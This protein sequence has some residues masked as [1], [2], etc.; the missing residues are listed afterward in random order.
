MGVR[1]RHGKG[2]QR[3]TA[4]SSF[5]FDTKIVLG[6]RYPVND[7]NWVVA[8]NGHYAIVLSLLYRQCASLT[9]VQLTN[10]QANGIK[11]MFVPFGR[12]QRRKGHET[13]SQRVTIDREV[14]T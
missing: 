3:V 2:G 10:T 8:V 6:D 1:L 5:T 4:E 12:E 7:A 9:A 14:Q 11:G 13:A